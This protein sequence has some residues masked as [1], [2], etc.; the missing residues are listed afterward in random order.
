MFKTV[1]K[2]NTFVA[3]NVYELTDEQIEKVVAKMEEIGVS[4]K[5]RYRFSKTVQE[6]IKQRNASFDN[7]YC[8]GLNLLYIFYS[9]YH[10]CWDWTLHLTS[11]DMRDMGGTIYG[12]DDF[13]EIDQTLPLE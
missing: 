1:F 12:Y 5:P 3:I 8:L 7:R 2:I 9:H 4:V 11:E 6:H 10:K 13:L